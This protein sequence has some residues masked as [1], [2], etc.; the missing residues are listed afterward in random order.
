[1]RIFA[2]LVGGVCAS[3]AVEDDHMSVLQSRAGVSSHVATRLDGAVA[4]KKGKC[5]ELEAAELV[6]CIRVG[7][8]NALDVLSGQQ[9]LDEAVNG[10]A[11]ELAQ[12][13]AEC[14]TL[15]KDVQCMMENPCYKRKV[16]QLPLDWQIGGEN[17]RTK[18][19]CDAYGDIQLFE[20]ADSTGK[21]VT[22]GDICNGK[23]RD[24]CE[25][26]NAHIP[27]VKEEWEAC[28]LTCDPT[29]TIE[30]EAEISDPAAVKFVAQRRWNS[31]CASEITTAA[32]C[33]N[34]AKTLRFESKG[35]DTHDRTFKVIRYQKRP[36][37]CYYYKKKV[38]WNKVQ[39]G[40]GPLKGRNPICVE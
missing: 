13:G 37:G 35:D 16:K 31:K 7:S 19:V 18:K 9:T 17:W 36:K 11:E 10:A 40:S 1:M 24:M 5:N 15:K 39:K 38:W 25:T 26:L 6:S 3:E 22:F 30:H 29:Q 8:H 28:G 34:A 23:F 4:G 32:D 12:T 20:A 33:E 21:D 14:K 27:A 2:L